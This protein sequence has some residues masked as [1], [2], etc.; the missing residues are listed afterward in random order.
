MR[1]LMFLAACAIV[2]ALSGPSE[3]AQISSPAIFGAHAQDRAECV[4][5]NSG[6]ANLTVTIKILTEAGG[7][8]QSR[9]CGPVPPNGFCTTSVAIPNGVAHACIATAGSIAR[10]RGTLV[11]QEGLDDGFGSTYFRAIR[12]APLK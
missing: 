4:I 11:I 9:A 6:T 7:T 5:L 1:I 3:A 2:L 10:L 8:L 12:S